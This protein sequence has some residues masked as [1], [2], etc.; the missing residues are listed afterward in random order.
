MYDRFRLGSFWYD[1]NGKLIQVYGG[2]Q[3]EKNAE[4][5]DR[6]HFRC[7]RNDSSDQMQRFC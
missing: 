6:D 4:K 7:K 1:T 5:F 2:M 3:K